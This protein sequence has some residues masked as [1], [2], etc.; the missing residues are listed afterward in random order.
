MGDDP[1]PAPRTPGVGDRGGGGEGGESLAFALEMLSRE[2]VLWGGRGAVLVGF[3]R[4]PQS[5]ALEPV[6]YCTKLELWVREWECQCPQG[7]GGSQ[8]HAEPQVPPI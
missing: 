3:Q 7:L 5:P 6:C 2:G 8:H 1:G 4:R